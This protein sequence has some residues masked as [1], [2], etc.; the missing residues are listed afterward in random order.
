MIAAVL[1]PALAAWSK[2]LFPALFAGSYLMVFVLGLIS[3]LLIGIAY[4]DVD[5]SGASTDAATRPV[6]SLWT[7]FR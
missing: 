3:A 4:R 1:G 6:R 5:I 2:N 7:V